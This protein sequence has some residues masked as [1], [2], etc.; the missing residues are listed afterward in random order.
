[1]KTMLIC[2]LNT[3]LM[4][5]GQ[6]LFKAGSIGYKINSI[7]DII[8]LFFTPVVFFAVC[9]YAGTTALWLFILNRTPISYAYPIQALAFPIVLTVSIVFFNES[10]SVMRWIGVAIIVLGVTIATRG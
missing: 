9:I 6:I 2:L 7:L 10:V 5:T 8:R 1:M 4:A 3:A